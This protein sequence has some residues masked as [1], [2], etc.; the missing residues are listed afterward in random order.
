MGYW[1]VESACRCNADVNGNGKPPR[2]RT[3]RRPLALPLQRGCERERQEIHA[4][5]YERSPSQR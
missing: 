3:T 4:T 5:Q 2:R 1:P